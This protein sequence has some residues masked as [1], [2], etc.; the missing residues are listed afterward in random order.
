MLVYSAHTGYPG[1]SIIELFISELKGYELSKGIIQ[2][3]YD[4][5][6]PVALI[7]KLVREKMKLNETAKPAKS[8]AKKSDVKK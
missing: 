6:L 7:K 5:P 2:F 1:A 4:K 8:F 3:P